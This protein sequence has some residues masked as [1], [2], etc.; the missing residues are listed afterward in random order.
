MAF[1]TGYILGDVPLQMLKKRAALRKK[2]K[3]AEASQKQAEA[4][5][6]N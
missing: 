3:A 1:A 6:L 2:K 5:N 4:E